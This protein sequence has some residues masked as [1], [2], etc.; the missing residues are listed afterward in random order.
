MDDG[1]VRKLFGKKIKMLREKANL[2]QE[3]LSV[4]LDIT[5]RQ[6]SMIERGLS[7]PKFKTLNKL[8]DIFNCKIQDLFDNDY[9]QDDLILKNLLKL[10]IDNSDYQKTRT[11]YL[12]AKNL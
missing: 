1:V 12:I 8:S 10:I 7:F 2:S 5:Q 9:L 3:E 6:I 11:L 4:K